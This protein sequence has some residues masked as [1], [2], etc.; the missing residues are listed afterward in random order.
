MFSPIGL[1]GGIN[2]LGQGV[3]WDPSQLAWEAERRAA[4]LA[5]TGIGRG[6]MVAIAHG[7]SARFFADLLATWRLGATAICLDSTLTT[8]E[9][10]TVLAFVKP[11]VL[12][13]DGADISRDV[14]VAVLRLAD[15]SSDVTVAAAEFNAADPAL[16]L[17]TSG[18]TGEPK[19][20]VLSFGALRTRLALNAETIGGAALARKHLTTGDADYRPST[21][22]KA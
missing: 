3:R 19:G 16:I 17:F 5:H 12:L 4:C 20:V 10:K 14:P 18:T 2:D 7:G 6:S 21:K 1:L 22:P 11:A 8:P 13:A 15:M 9:L